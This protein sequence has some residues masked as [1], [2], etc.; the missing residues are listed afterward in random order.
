MMVNGRI[1]VR[2]ENDKAVM[3]NNESDMEK[4]LKTSKFSNIH[5]YINFQIIFFI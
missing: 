4:L 1:F 5:M 2:T 3:L